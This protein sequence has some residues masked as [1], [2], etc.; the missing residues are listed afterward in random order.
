VVEQIEEKMSR[1]LKFKAVFLI[2]LFS[3]SALL[4]K[5]YGPKIPA[6]YMPSLLYY[7]WE[8]PIVTAFVLCRVKV[9]FSTALA[10]VVVAFC[11]FKG[12]SDA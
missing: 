10:S 3:G 6:P 8:I 5:F 4:L 11:S 9:G 7:L 2:V 1:L 12:K